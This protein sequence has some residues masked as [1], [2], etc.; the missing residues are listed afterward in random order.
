MAEALAQYRALA[1]DLLG[2]LFVGDA[3]GAAVVVAGVEHLGR[4]STAAGA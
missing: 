3:A 1:A 4:Q 2:V